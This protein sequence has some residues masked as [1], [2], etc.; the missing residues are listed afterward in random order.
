MEA[1]DK[2]E[3]RMT[4]V[5][6]ALFARSVSNDVGEKIYYRSFL[7][8]NANTGCKKFTNKNE[9]QIFFLQ[10]GGPKNDFHNIDVD[11]DGFAC[12]WDP[13]IYRKI[14][15]NRETEPSRN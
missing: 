3:I 13:A 15:L 6:L 1:D 9:A 11:G 4:V 5:N 10:N 8:T 7:G 2:E 14:K 12:E